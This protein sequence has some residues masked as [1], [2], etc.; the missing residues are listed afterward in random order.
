MRMAKA[1]LLHLEGEDLIRVE[2]ENHHEADRHTI[3]NR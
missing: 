2:F 3:G 1:N